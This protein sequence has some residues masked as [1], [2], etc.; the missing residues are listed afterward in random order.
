MANMKQKPLHNW[1]PI[2]ESKPLERIIN[3]PVYLKMEC[4]QPTGS[5]KI[6]GLGK[7]CQEYIAA[8]KKHLV[9]SSAGNAGY[10]TAYIGRKLGVDV[11]VFVPTTT[12]PLFRERIQH[13]AANLIIAGEDFDEAN[14]Q[15]Q[16][17][18]QEINGAF[19]PPFDHP[20]IWS[21]HSSLIDEI[22]EDKIK[23]DAIIIAVGG[24]GLLCGIL[25][26][27]YHHDWKNIPI[28]A[29]E[30]VGSA[31]LAASMKAKK[32]ITLEKID[33]IAT[34]LGAKRV[35]QKTLDWSQQHPITSIIVTDNE[36]LHACYRFADDH[37]VL[38][39]PACGAALATIYEQHQEL[40]N[41]KSLLVI[42]CGGIGVS[43]HLLEEW[44]QY[45]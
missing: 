35:A 37:R 36:A 4:F 23:P 18:T 16:Q 1:T 2:F 38:V 30:T 5:F 44:C 6:R 20:D 13:Q 25:Q 8:G 9:S 27:L 12:I 41:A 28:F 21:G 43:M 34:S 19:I 3:K 26:G 17:F 45:K 33:T 40:I 29:V 15:A 24:G 14:Q 10:S 7:L 32:L 42:V 31:S 11:T 39:E 22:V